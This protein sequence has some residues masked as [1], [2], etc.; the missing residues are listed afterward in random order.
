MGAVTNARRGLLPLP[1][2]DRPGAAPRDVLSPFAERARPTGA[3]AVRAAAP[4]GDGVALV[5]AR[6]VFEEAGSEP[7]AI[8]AAS[9]SVLW[10]AMWAAGMSAEEMADYSL[11]WRPE[12]ALGV[13]WIGVPRLAASALRGFSG[14]ARGAALESLFPRQVWRMCAGETEIPLHTVGYD[15]DARRV[16]PLGSEATPE[17]TL[18]ELALIAVTPPRR[19][20]AVRVEGAFVT[21]PERKEAL[22]ALPAAPDALE[23]PAGDGGFYDLFLDRRRWPELIRAGYA[24]TSTRVPIVSQL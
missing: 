11:S 18:G 14:L 24:Y 23:L 3:L 10:A 9:A 16:E 5:G 6:R 2:V 19:G 7:S 8:A 1:L 15:I 12:G 4:G 13:Q 17:L 22:R 21:A 20:E